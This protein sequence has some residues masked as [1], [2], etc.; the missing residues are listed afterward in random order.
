M[1]IEAKVNLIVRYTVQYWAGEYHKCR[2][3]HN[4]LVDFHKKEG[5]Q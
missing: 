1:G 5:G 4:S 3:R 2:A